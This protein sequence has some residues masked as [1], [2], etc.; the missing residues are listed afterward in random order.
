MAFDISATLFFQIIIDIF[1]LYQVSQL[2]Y[3]F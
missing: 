3:K 1:R 2:V